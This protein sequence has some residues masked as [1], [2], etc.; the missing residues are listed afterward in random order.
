M[1]ERKRERPKRR[2]RDSSDPAAVRGREESTHAC[3]AM[4]NK[5]D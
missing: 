4:C 1:G 3:R 5:V 2:R